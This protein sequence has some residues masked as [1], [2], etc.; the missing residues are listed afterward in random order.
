MTIKHIQSSPPFRCDVCNRPGGMGGGYY[1]DLAYQIG[2]P[3]PWDLVCAR[4]V[5]HLWDAL[6]VRQMSRA[7]PPEPPTETW[8]E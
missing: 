2:I 7:R 3:G 1:E 5:D 8:E 6:G 4:C